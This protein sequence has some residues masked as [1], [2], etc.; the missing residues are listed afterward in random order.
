MSAEI[1]FEFFRA[2]MDSLW[3]TKTSESNESVKVLAE[4]TMK[5]TRNIMRLFWGE[6]I[7]YARDSFIAC[8]KC[9]KHSVV[10]TED[11]YHGE[12]ISK[13]NT[14]PAIK[15]GHSAR[16]GICPICESDELFGIKV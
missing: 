12:K 9:K 6:S 10:V 16:F 1:S 3:K 8:K 11:I 7:A 2:R 4:S 13:N 5:T 14:T 15:S